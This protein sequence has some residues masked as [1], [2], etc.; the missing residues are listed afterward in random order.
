MTLN[1]TTRPTKNIGVDETR[2]P[3]A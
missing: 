1:F 3:S 2:T